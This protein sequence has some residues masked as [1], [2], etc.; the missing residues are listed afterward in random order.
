[1]VTIAELGIY[2]SI[3]IAIAVPLL[4]FYLQRHVNAFDKTQSKSTM[5]TFNI[6]TMKDEVKEIK[7]SIETSRD[8]VDKR[9]DRILIEMEKKDETWKQEMRR[10]VDKVDVNSTTLKL[11]EYRLDR[12]EKVNKNG[13]GGSS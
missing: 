12:L 6:G 5:A 3:T 7:E 4:M 11:V 8:Y 9:L 1:L 10:M 13:G 2:V